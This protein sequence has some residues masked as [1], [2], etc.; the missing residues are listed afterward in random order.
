MLLSLLIWVLFVI[1]MDSNAGAVNAEVMGTSI[2]LSDTI[3]PTA[4]AGPDQ[5]VSV[6]DDVRFDASLSAD[7]GGSIA[8][9]TWSFTYTEI[10]TKL[11]GERPS[12][13]FEKAVTYVVTLNVTDAN[14]LSGTD[15]VDIKVVAKNAD[16]S[17]LIYSGGAAAA[18]ALLLIVLFV[19]MRSRKS[20][21]GKEPVDD[22]EEEF[23][24]A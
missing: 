23:E 2:S 20:N 15:Q 22:S 8:N 17:T 24:E 6:G 13:T 16:T 11:Y 14:N 18:V 19:F 7:A 9:Y 1:P 10:D 4:N 21:G 3:K 5:N 12:F